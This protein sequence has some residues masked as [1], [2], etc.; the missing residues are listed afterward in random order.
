MQVDRL[1]VLFT[2]GSLNL[3]MFKVC[4]ITAISE[5]EFFNF[6]GTES[7]KQNQKKTKN[8]LKPPKLVSQ[9]LF[10]QFQ[11]IPNVFLVFH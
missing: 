5:I 2:F 3:L 8:Q 1:D 4:G 6:C 10:K 9:S 11:Q 7:V